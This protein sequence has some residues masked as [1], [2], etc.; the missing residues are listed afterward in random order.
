MTA[1]CDD[2]TMEMKLINGL[3][4]GRYSLGERC[5]N[6]NSTITIVNN[7]EEDITYWGIAADQDRIVNWIL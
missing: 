7:V 3:S 6:G 5:D 2:N 1:K 4:A